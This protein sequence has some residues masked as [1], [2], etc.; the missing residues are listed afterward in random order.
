MSSNDA[1]DV[2]AVLRRIEAAYRDPGLV[3]LEG[4]HAVKHAF[5][6]G[7]RPLDLVTDDA[8]AL[9]VML[10]DL[11]GVDH[12]VVEFVRHHTLVCPP[13]ALRA[14]ARRDPASA[15]LAVASRRPSAVA[16]VV[17][18]APGV[19]VALDEPR[20]AGNAGAVVRVAA[21]AEAGAVIM[22]G[23]LDAWSAPVVRASAGL[24][25]ALPVASTPDR[26]VLC[27]PAARGSRVVVALDP[28]GAPFHPEAVPDDAILVFGSERHGLG[29]DVRAAADHCLALPMRS[30][31]SSLNL[32][33]SVAAVVYAM[34]YGARGRS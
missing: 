22:V 4:F 21:A 28:E 29:A 12:E 1:P 10:A 25:W 13:G 30:G 7:G 23:A 3:V 26:S 20:H 32:A 34:R 27:D 6:F 5:V 14:V 9:D 31:V 24:H 18:R 2:D 15:L 17:A 33:T 8:A 11:R 19:V 16:D